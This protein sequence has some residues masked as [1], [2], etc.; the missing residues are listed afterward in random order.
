MRGG[1]A[2]PKGG[3]LVGSP[4]YSPPTPTNPWQI[5]F[6]LNESTCSSHRSDHHLVVEV[7]AGPRSLTCA[8]S[9]AYIIL[10]HQTCVQGIHCLP[11]L[12]VFSLHFIFISLLNE[13]SLEDWPL[14]YKRELFYFAGDTLLD[15][16]HPSHIKRYASKTM[17]IIIYCIRA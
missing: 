11:S 6:T 8:Q 10:E 9:N 4:A 2:Q 15:L 16:F 3:I 17:I 1:S 7:D 12:Y 5:V 13:R 14:Y